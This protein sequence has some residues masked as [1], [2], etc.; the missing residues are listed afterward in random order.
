MN[1]VIDGYNLFFHIEDEANPL[2]KKRELFI[3]ALHDALAELHLHATLIFDSHQSHAA[4]FPTKKD[5]VA[6]EIIFS[7]EG[8]SADEYILERL[9]AEKKPQ[10]Q[11]VVTSDRELIRHAKHLGAK[12]KTIESF[13]EMLAH[14]HAKKSP[15]KEEKMHK[16]SSHHFDRLLEAF[17]KKLR[18][19]SSD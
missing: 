3:A 12:T 7:P 17:E 19:E 8:F 13:F 16:E 14:R 10:L 5:L 1:Y 2:E 15:K 9:R 4:V 11:I 18:D 6:L